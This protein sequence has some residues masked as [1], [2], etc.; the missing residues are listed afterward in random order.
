MS[1]KNNLKTRRRL[2]Q[3]SLKQEAQAAKKAKRKQVKKVVKDEVNIEVNELLKEFDLSKERTEAK[4]RATQDKAAAK[5]AAAKSGAGAA[6]GVQKPNFNVAKFKRRGPRLRK[7]AVVRGI[8]IVDAATR[9]EVEEI[10]ARE[11]EA[12]EAAMEE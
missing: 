10:L 11:Q 9:K 8:K 6:A 5:G 2:H 1:K 7:G 3:Y 4:K 12:K